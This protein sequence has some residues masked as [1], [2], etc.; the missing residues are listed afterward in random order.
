MQ[1][2]TVVTAVLDRFGVV[3]QG[4]EVA[5]FLGA[6]GFSGAKFW[7]VNSKDGSWCV[8]RW[9]REHPS[10]DRL[11]WIH[12]VLQH[13]WK[14]GFRQLPLPRQDPQGASFVEMSGYLWE[15]TPWLPGQACEPGD[16]SAAMLETAVQAL[17]KFHQAVHDFAG[18]QVRRRTS[19]GLQD[20][21]R[22][23]SEM[24]GGGLNRIRERLGTCPQDLLVRAQGILEFASQHVASVADLLSKW[25]RVELQLQPCIRDIHREHVLFE[26][27]CL[28][29]IID[30]GAM[31]EDTVVTDLA[32]LLGSLVGTSRDDWQAG[33]DFYESVRPLDEAEQQ[34][35]LCFDQAN[36][37][38]SPLNWLQWLLVENRRFDDNDRVLHRLDELM[39]R[40]P[41]R[42]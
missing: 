30:F 28:S 31:N 34:V 13:A 41:G 14:S 3:Y 35:L 42:V 20:R 19:P 9:P 29:G 12:G 23:V 39:L 26:G 8:R 15:V 33:L 16:V 32:R 10:T 22:L 27:T 17:A 18:R 4:H 11:R 36:I 1:S 37:L 6:N 40:F 2:E 25:G 21:H 24:V 5:P 38:L 7:R